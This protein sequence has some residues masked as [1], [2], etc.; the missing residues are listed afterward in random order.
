MVSDGRLSIVFQDRHLAVVAK[1]AGLVT[2]PYVPGGASS[3]GSRRRRPPQ[4]SDEPSLLGLA[5]EVLG[6]LHVVQ[7][8]DRETTGLIVLARTDHARRGLGQQLR[9]HSVERGYLALVAGE[10]PAKRTYT[11]WLVADRGDGRRGSWRGRRPPPS[12]RRAVTHVRRLRLVEQLPTGAGPVSLVACRLETGRQ[13]QIR[14]HLAEAGHPLVGERIY[15]EPC[16]R[17]AGPRVLL[18]AG[19]LGFVHPTSGKPLRFKLDPDGAFAE[20]LVSRTS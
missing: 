7:R 1:P 12:A 2:A 8:L 3:R 9:Q 17:L 16:R 19:I 14:I 20:A 6:R 13:H 5:E 15:G 4:A 11:S 18:H 10:H